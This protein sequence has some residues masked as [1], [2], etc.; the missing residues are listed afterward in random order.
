MRELFDEVAGQS[1]L[2]PNE[3]AR[4]ELSMRSE[5][6]FAITSPKSLPQ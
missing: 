5:L 6:D 4:P 1:P 2:D 3:A